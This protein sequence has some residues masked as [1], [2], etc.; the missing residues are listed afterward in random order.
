MDDRQIHNV[1]HTLN[2]SMT[3]GGCIFSS[4]M[5]FQPIGWVFKSSRQLQH[6]TGEKSDGVPPTLNK[7]A[8]CGETK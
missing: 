4:I 8:Y 2:S 6:A 3:W 5:N 7:S 1:L